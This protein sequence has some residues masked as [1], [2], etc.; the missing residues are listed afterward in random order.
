MSRLMTSLQQGCQ[1]GSFGGKN[2]KFGSFEKQLA[3]KILFGYLATFW[4]FYNFF[5]PQLFLEELRVGSIACP[6]HHDHK[7]RSG[8][9]HS[10]AMRYRTEHPGIGELRKDRE[11]VQVERTTCPMQCPV[12]LFSCC[13]LHFLNFN[14]SARHELH[15]AQAY[16][17]S[18]TQIE[19]KAICYEVVVRP[20]DYKH[21]N[22]VVR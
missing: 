16:S 15:R 8:L 5:V 20:Q 22:T 17:V 1:I 11:D 12:D 9:P 2:K 7:T 21:F 19:H 13:A 18:T 4:L 10:C 3:P 14:V 6:R